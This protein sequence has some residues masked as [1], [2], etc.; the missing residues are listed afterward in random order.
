MLSQTRRRAT[1]HHARAIEAD[2]RDDGL[3]RPI[4][5]AFI[6]RHEAAVVRMRM[7]HQ[8]GEAVDQRAGN[9][10]RREQIDPFGRAALPNHGSDSGDGL[11][12]MAHAVGVGA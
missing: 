4:G 1:R 9:A 6:G 11:L 10:F 2:G 7:R 8:I 3:Q 12:A 5:F